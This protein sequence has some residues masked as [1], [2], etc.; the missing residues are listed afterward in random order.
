MKPSSAAAA[1]PAA[2][3]R[4]VFAPPA[5]AAQRCTVDGCGGTITYARNGD[6]EAVA[7]CI[8][9]N[10]RREWAAKNVPNFT[11]K[12]CAICGGA[13]APKLGKTRIASRTKYC[14]PCGRLTKLAYSRRRSA[15]K[16][17]SGK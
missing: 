10:R 3:P 17:G 6:G 7:S 2:P 15:E 12:A 8:F 16:R 11:P 5:Q 1:T 14:P 4:S 13:I 9:C